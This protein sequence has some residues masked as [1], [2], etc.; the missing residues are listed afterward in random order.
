M[1]WTCPGVCWTSPPLLARGFFC[2]FGLPEPACIILLSPGFLSL[3]TSPGAR[4]ED[5]GEGRGETSLGVKFYLFISSRTSLSGS[6]A[7]LLGC[8][9]SGRTPYLANRHYCGLN[10]ECGLSSV[11]GLISVGSV[12][13]VGWSVWALGHLDWRSSRAWSWSSIFFWIIIR[14]KISKSSAAQTYTESQSFKSGNKTEREQKSLTC[15]KRPCWKDLL[16]PFPQ[17]SSNCLEVIPMSSM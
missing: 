7:A 6:V 14:L 4:A 15:S 9:D 16:D 1:A 10:S 13:C 17:A 3:F 12:V 11:C 2:T 8:R 5:W